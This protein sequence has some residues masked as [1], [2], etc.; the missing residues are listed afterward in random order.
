MI[1]PF[2]SILIM[3]MPTGNKGHALNNLRRYEEALVALKQAIR[4][5]PKDAD[6]YNE[7][8]FA[9]SGLGKKKEANQAHKKAR[10]LGYSS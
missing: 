4:L 5:D 10:Q 8:Y 6:A 7:K 9:L 2:T 3:L 1:K